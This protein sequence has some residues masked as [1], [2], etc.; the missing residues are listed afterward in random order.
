M[1]VGLIIVQMP[2]GVASAIRK[3]PHQR[4]RIA[5]IIRVPG[6][7]PKP[8]LH[9]FARVI[10]IGFESHQLMVAHRFKQKSNNPERN[11]EHV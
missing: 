9:H 8:A 4:V 5:E 1:I 6:V 10:G 3:R 2:P 11:P 7:G